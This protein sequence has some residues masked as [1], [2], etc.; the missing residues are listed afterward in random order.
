MYQGLT[1][2]Q[3]LLVNHEDIKTFNARWKVQ[4]QAYIHCKTH[5]QDS[6]FYLLKSGTNLQFIHRFYGNL[7]ASENTNKIQKL[8]WGAR[9]MITSGMNC[10]NTWSAACTCVDVIPYFFWRP[11]RNMRV[12]SLENGLS[13]DQR[14]CAGSYM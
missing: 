11:L 7:P 5:I 8:I 12:D 6:T 2:D 13:D 10:S 1:N 14:S 9:K 4:E 3:F